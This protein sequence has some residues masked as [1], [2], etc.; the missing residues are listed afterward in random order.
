[1]D[2]FVEEPRSNRLVKAS[3]AIGGVVLMALLVMHVNGG[4][5]KSDSLLQTG[6]ALAQM[7]VAQAVAQPQAVAPQPQFAQAQAVAQPQAVAPQPQFAQAP[8][9]APVQ[10]QALPAAAPAPVAAAPVAPP[11]P[12]QTCPAGQ[13]PCARPSCGA[14]GGCWSLP[15]GATAYVCTCM[16]PPEAGPVIPGSTA[17]LEKPENQVEGPPM[18]A[19][20]GS[21]GMA[22]YETGKVAMQLDRYLKASA[23]K[24]AAQAE[25]GKIV[26][27][28]VKALQPCPLKTAEDGTVTCEDGSDPKD[29]KS[30]GLLG[31][32]FLGL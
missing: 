19:A 6:S 15:A 7:A 29:R 2:D 16:T 14:I 24:A 25:L 20:M 26:L 17:W 5:T 8:Q 28:D 32:G 3:A 22:Q 31:L 9:Y 1:M 12:A 4:V 21:M 10:G 30:K 11:A 23:D 13:T 18:G 27:D